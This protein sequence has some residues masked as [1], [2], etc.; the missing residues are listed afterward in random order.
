M[1]KFGAST[2]TWL[3]SQKSADVIFHMPNVDESMRQ[4]GLCLLALSID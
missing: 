4:V 2:P 3:I 1:R